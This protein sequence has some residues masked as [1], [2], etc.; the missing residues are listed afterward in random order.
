MPLMCYCFPYVG[1]DYRLTSSQPGTSTHWETA[2]TGYC[3][4][5]CVC[6]LSQLLLATHWAYPWRDGSGWVDQGTW[7]CRS[8]RCSSAFYLL[9]DFPCT[10][11]A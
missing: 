3:I 11:H 9:V 4:T 10:V 2:D 1:A 7:F 5:R 8:T 6:L